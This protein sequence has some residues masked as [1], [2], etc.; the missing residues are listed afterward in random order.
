M[1]GKKS[2]VSGFTNRG[3]YFGNIWCVYSYKCQ[4]SLVL[5]SDGELAHWILFLE[6]EH[7]VNRFNLNPP[8]Q[9]DINT[10][11]KLQFNAEVQYKSGEL[12]WRKIS[13]DWASSS[14]LAMKAQYESISECNHVKFSAWCEEDFIPH[15]YKIMSLLKVAACLS[16]GKRYNLPVGLSYD[17]VCYVKNK[18]S[19]ML[20]EF[21]VAF[22]EYD[23]SYV[24]YEF[25]KL[26]ADSIIDVEF[27]TVFFAEGTRWKVI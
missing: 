14:G 26:F 23:L 18:Q 2:Q 8:I 12:E 19:G 22:S 25:S 15:K 7:S 27:G 16:A 6:F 21:L 11:E 13:S 1:S 20:A 24:Y 17:A 9:T 3:S 4:D 5:H 10:G